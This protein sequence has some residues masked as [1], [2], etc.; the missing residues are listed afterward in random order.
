MIGSLSIRSF[1]SENF[2]GTVWLSFGAPGTL[3]L[4]STNTAAFWAVFCVGACALGSSLPVLPDGVD[5]A[6]SP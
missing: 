6:C 3:S 2:A 1:R 5:T 4:P